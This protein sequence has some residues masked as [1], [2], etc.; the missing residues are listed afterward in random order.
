MSEHLA[1]AER[2]T[3]E[4]RKVGLQWTGPYVIAISPDDAARQLLALWRGWRS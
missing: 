4:E 1:V 2:S 3:D